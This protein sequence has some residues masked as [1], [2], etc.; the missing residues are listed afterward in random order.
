MRIEVV[1]VECSVKYKSNTGRVPKFPGFCSDC[2]K[3][4]KYEAG[5][6]DPV[7]REKQTEQNRLWKK[8]N[9]EQHKEI[10]RAY[11][12]AHHEEIIVKSRLYQNAN[13]EAVIEG[14]R[15]RA[16]AKS[17][18]T[19][20]KIRNIICMQC[21]ASDRKT[22]KSSL[23]SN[24]CAKC[25]SSEINRSWPLENPDAERARQHRR[26]ARVNG[27]W[28]PN[29]TKEDKARLFKEQKGRCCDCNCLFDNT[30]KGKAT[31]AHLNPLDGSDVKGSNWSGNIALQC[32]SCNSKQGTKT[33]PMATLSL[34]DRVIM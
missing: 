21:G 13:R 31:V 11:K 18:I 16:R 1:C 27:V 20:K 9:P 23:Y 6:A 15:K 28:G 14:N 7:Q 5:R 17:L 25:R 32:S 10:N 2:A 22:S 29:F 3:H 12:I 30:K 24:L 8:N 4:K 33:H 26:R 34:F 19:P